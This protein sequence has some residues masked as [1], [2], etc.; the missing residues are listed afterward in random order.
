[1]DINCKRCHEPI[2]ASDVNLG[3]NIAKC[4]KCDAVF[5]FRDQIQTYSRIVRRE[6]PTPE[7]MTLQSTMDGLEIIRKW[8]SPKVYGLLVFCILWDGF[9]VVWFFIALT[10]KQW[11]MA[12]FGTIHGAV[13]VGLT[14]LLVCSFINRTHIQINFRELKIFHEPL[15]WPGKKVIPIGEVK[16]GFTKEK[17]HRGKN[18]TRYTYDVWYL[19]QADEEHKLLSGLD[20]LEHALYV[21]QEIEKTLGIKD[22]PVSGEVNR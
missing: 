22:T 14:Y 4:K 18:S 7:T 12:A 9:M 2:P 16:Q 8:F 20:R 15:P 11:A 6:V 19:D 17:I 5:D 1:M 3:T 13:G 21:E 10:Q